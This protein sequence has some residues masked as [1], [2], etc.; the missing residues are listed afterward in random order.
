MA[1]QLLVGLQGFR[2]PLAARQDSLRGFLVLPELRL[3]NLFFEEI[4]FLAALA[5][6]SKKTP[7]GGGLL[8]EFI[9]FTL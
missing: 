3:G 1:G 7:N 5:G 2:Q 9:K 6:A 8:L 4:Q